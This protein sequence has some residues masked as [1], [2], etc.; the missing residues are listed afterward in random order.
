MESYHHTNEKN[1]NLRTSSEK[2]R[3]F[4]LKNIYIFLSLLFFSLLSRETK[5]KNSSFKIII[6]FF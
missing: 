3:M 5:K 2:W 6:L 1:A 4:I